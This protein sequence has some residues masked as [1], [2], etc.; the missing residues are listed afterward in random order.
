MVPARP[1][2]GYDRA[3]V[4]V[5]VVARGGGGAFGAV[6]AARLERAAVRDGDDVRGHEVARAHDEGFRR[7]DRSRPRDGDDADAVREVAKAKARAAPVPRGARVVRR[8]VEDAEKPA[9]APA[10]VEEVPRE[11]AAALPEK[12]FRIRPLGDVDLIAE[13]R[14]AAGHQPGAVCAGSF[15]HV[16]VAA[17]HERAA[18]L[19]KRVAIRIAV[20]EADPA[21]GQFAVCEVEARARRVQDDRVDDARRVRRADDAAG[22]GGDVETAALRPR[23]GAVQVERPRPV[24][25][26]PLVVHRHRPGQFDAVLRV[27]VVEVRPLFDGAGPGEDVAPGVRPAAAL[28][29]AAAEDDRA[30]QGRVG[31][32]EVERAAGHAER[33]LGGGGEAGR[34]LQGDRGRDV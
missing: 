8:A 23:H 28:K 31:L 20:A 24:L 13:R 6:E 15:A 29:G 16:G 22:G 11:R 32:P 2:G 9:P 19:D 5:D 1:E 3:A 4:H 33:R 26:D 21:G 25:D 12:T 14:R 30:G 10:D 34:V 18:R 27:A 17:D 7:D